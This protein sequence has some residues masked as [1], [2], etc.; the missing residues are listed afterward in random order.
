MDVTQIALK[1]LAE[2][3]SSPSKVPMGTQTRNATIKTRLMG[4]DATQIAQPPLVVM[5]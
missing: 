1:P 4:M 2:M 3:A 5:G